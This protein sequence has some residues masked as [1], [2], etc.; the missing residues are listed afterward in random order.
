M[1]QA[2]AVLWS[3]VAL[4]AAA[5]AAAQ[6]TNDEV[7]R[8]VQGYVCRH[9]YWRDYPKREGRSFPLTVGRQ[10]RW[11]VAWLED[12]EFFPASIEFA[13]RPTVA[14]EYSYFLQ[15]GRKYDQGVVLQMWRYRKGEAKPNWI[16]EDDERKAFTGTMEQVPFAEPTHCPSRTEDTPTKKRIT[17][18]ILETVRSQLRSF[19]RLPPGPDP[20]FNRRYPEDAL[21]VVIGSFTLDEDS[22]DIY[23]PLTRE[24][25]RIALHDRQSSGDD[26]YVA[27]A[28]FPFGQEH[29]PSRRLISM[30]ERDGRRYE[31]SLRD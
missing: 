1:T 26:D 24:V 31:I 23:V 13:P 3:A 20:R 18:A 5:P 28:A 6:L 12:M 21:T 25:F 14:P 4:A 16:Y 27:N 2:L 11:T 10:D 9:D 7:V 15:L 17:S 19:N 8:A 29:R 22:V 30:I